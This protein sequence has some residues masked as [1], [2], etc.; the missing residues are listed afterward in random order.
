MDAKSK[1]EFINSV[2]S[3]ASIPCQKCGANNGPDSR[4]CVICGAELKRP[5]QE[6]EQVPA[7]EPAKEETVPKE[8][9]SVQSTDVFA[10]GLPDWSVVPPQIMVRRR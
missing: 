9:E 7:F 6:V 2:A 8:M 4:Y 1:A 5:Q 10:Q 3:G